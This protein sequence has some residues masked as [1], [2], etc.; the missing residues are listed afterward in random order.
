MSTLDKPRE[1][2]DQ[3]HKVSNPKVPHSK[4]KYLYRNIFAHNLTS[5]FVNIIFYFGFRAACSLPFA[6]NV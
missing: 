3:I 6:A 4:L 5:Y 2:V 1:Y